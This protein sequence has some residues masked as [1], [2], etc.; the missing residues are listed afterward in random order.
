L[1]KRDYL[2]S[3]KIIRWSGEK[4]LKRT[5]IIPD[6]STLILEPGTTLKLGRKVSMIVHGELKVNGTKDNLVHI[7]SIKENPKPRDY[8]GSI[9]F[10]HSLSDDS[11]MKY[12][13]V[14]YGNEDHLMGVYCTGALSVY[15][16]PFVL[17]DSQFRYCYL[18]S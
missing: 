6:N 17:E 16:V 18:Q 13:L 7:T 3:D 5:V 12:A 4:I 10:I 11:Y 1:R 2:E 15:H 14:E 9:C 8:W